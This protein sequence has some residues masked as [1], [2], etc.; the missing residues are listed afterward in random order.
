MRIT[1]NDTTSDAHRVMTDGGTP[2]HKIAERVASRAADTVSDE[3]DRWAAD[4][5][6]DDAHDELVEAIQY[7][8]EKSINGRLKL[9]AAEKY[10]HDIVTD[11]GQTQTERIRAVF[12][13]YDD[14]A[15]LK[16]PGWNTIANH[17][18]LVD[19]GQTHREIRYFSR[20]AIE[21]LSLTVVNE[22]HPLW[23]DEVADLEPGEMLRVDELRGESDD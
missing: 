3:L 11:G 1:T 22:D 7:S 17:D 14:D 21:G 4:R 6:D 2:R 20:Q 19:A 18:E 5:L 8:V 10:E 9:E 13:V 12:T 15:D 16:T 23:C